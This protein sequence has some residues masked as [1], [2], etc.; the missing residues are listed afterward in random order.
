MIKVKAI[1]SDG[2]TFHYSNTLWKMLALEGV[3][4]PEI[5]IFKENRGLGNG[6][7]ITNLRKKARQVKLVSRLKDMN[8][9]STERKKVIAFH[10]ASYT[11]TLEVTYLDVTRDI[12]ECR[13][14]AFSYPTGK[15]HLSPQLTVEFLSPYAVLFADF[16]DTEQMFSVMPM[17]FSDRTYAVESYPRLYGIEARETEKSII[18]NGSEPAPLIVTITASGLITENIEIDLNDIVFSVDCDLESGDV[19]K[20]DA[21]NYDVYK[22][23]VLLSPSLYTSETFSNMALAIGNNVIKIN[24]GDNLAFTSEISYTGRYDGI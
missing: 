2:E 1:R 21:E 22:N 19:L 24:S 16:T 10:N 13:L 4:A 3:D 17:W 20:I 18:Y 12:K 11:Y 6:A 7:I 8:V 23:D 14:E 15:T 9:D 5:E